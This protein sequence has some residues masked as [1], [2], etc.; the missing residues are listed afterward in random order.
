KGSYIAVSSAGLKVSEV[1]GVNEASKRMDLRFHA[2]SAEKT[3]DIIS[4][5]KLTQEGLARGFYWGLPE[6]SP[7]MNKDIRELSYTFVAYK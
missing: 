2:R 6:D 5:W 7:E 4:P 1:E 3:V